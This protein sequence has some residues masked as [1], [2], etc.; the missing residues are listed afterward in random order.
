VRE[1]AAGTLDPARRRALHGAIVDMLMAGGEPAVS[2]L[3]LLA[4]HALAAGRPELC[5]RTAIE[6][7]RAALQANAPEEV[8]RLVSLATPVATS[9]ADRIDL[10]RLRDDAL[11]VLRRPA[12]RIEGLSELSALAEASGDLHLELDVMLRR[13]AA[14]RLSEDEETATA[15]ARRVRERAAEVGDSAAELAA[16]VE[17]GQCLLNA[18]LGDATTQASSEADFDGAQEAYSRALTLAEAAD[19]KRMIAATSRELGVI[20]TGRIREWFVDR[21]A[22]DEHIPAMK[23]LL[24]GVSMEEIVADLPI[25]PIVGEAFGHFERAL[26]LYEEL[27]DRKGVMSTVVAM[28]AASW[29]PGIHLSGSVQHIE[30]IRR[31]TARVKSFTRESERALADAQMLYGSQVYSRIRGFPDAALTKGVEAFNAARAIGDRTIEFAA[32]GG[33][34]LQHAELGAIEE[35]ERW[36][37]RAAA[38]ATA[39]PTPFR[40]LQ[41]ELWRGM[42]R[43]EAGD[44]EGMRSRLGQ[45]VAV[46]NE[47]GRP[48]ARCEALALFATHAA[49]LGVERDDQALIADAERTASEAESLAATLPGHPP[50]R[51]L[52][53]GARARILLARAE[54]AEATRTGRDALALLRSAYHEDFH[55]DALLPAARAVLAGG[56]EEERAG[57]HDQLQL[58]AAMIAQ[59][60]LDDDVRVRWFGSRIG[61]ELRELGGADVGVLAAHPDSEAALE[62]DE[63]RL[64]QL[65]TEARSNAEIAATLGVSEE[66]AAQQLAR[67]FAKIGVASRADATTLA[68][69]GSLV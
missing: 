20:A 42:V 33:L 45:A 38:V 46:A 61:K 39:S 53:M 16:C 2:G 34:G 69:T 47:Q 44:V 35:A 64:L 12:Q 37:S 11:A 48:A 66:A 15:V 31:L 41:L 18:E 54:V 28:A 55:F 22:A 30:E 26:T 52:A 59:R 1:Y 50:W 36:M 17:L 29:A 9:A 57:V 32:A 8:L 7:G 65:V 14:L 3:S 24:A 23:A 51:A 67:L 56:T 13:A 4:G 40:A 62:D 21:I 49:R 6:A 68:L 58:L 25:A 27:G 63:R 19:D 5:S 60:V 43:A 10:L